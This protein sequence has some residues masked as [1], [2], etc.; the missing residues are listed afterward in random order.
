MPLQILI[1]M[2]I[3]FTFILIF[4]VNLTFG[5]DTTYFDK[6][7]KKVLNKQTAEFYE[8]V[9]HDSI[10]SNKV[11]L[12]SYFI[13]GKIQSETNYSNFKNKILDGKSRKY[14][15]NGQILFEMDYKN[16]LRNGQLL[17]YW[18]NGKLKRIDIYE[19]DKLVNGRCLDSIGNELK[20]FEYEKMPEFPGGVQALKKYLRLSVNYP[21]AALDKKI[22]GKVFVGFVVN[23]D[24]SL[25]N[26]SIV[27]GV[28]FPLDREA[29][30]VVQSMPRWIPGQ[31]D[32]INVR[33]SFTLPINFVL[34]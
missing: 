25:A 20:Y 21:K 32:G 13:S 29:M 9:L 4:V 18:P 24:G 15:E 26:V 33:V 19:N 14:L 8:I 3:L 5:Q 12:K 31:Q 34:E 2:K 6:K 7:W 23:T 11:I 28:S 30:R 27:R 22:Q 16:N 10:D 1:K 17:R